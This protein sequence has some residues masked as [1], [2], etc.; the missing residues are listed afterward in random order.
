[1]DMLLYADEVFELLARAASQASKAG[2][3]AW[4]SRSSQTLRLFA[5]VNGQKLPTPNMNL[6]IGSY[7]FDFLEML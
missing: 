3:M 2:F 6:W 1:M 7:K 5:Q 4:K